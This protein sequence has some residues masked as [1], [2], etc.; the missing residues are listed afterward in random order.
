MTRRLASIVAAVLI[1][2][3]AA[4]AFAQPK[5]DPARAAFIQAWRAKVER[6]Y[7][8]PDADAVQQEIDAK[9]RIIT[10]LQD[11]VA[12]CNNCPKRDSLKRELA[13]ARG[14]SG[15]EKAGNGHVTEIYRKE[16]VAEDCLVLLEAYQGCKA[17]KGGDPSEDGP[18]GDD[19]LLFST[20]KDGQ[21]GHFAQAMTRKA[22]RDAGQTIPRVTGTFAAVFGPVPDSF[23]PPV[24]PPS[25]LEGERELA[26]TMLKSGDGTLTEIRLYTLDEWVY[27]YLLAGRLPFIRAKLTTETLAQMEIVSRAV[28]GINDAYVLKCAYKNGP[29]LQKI[30]A[31][32][33]DHR[34]DAPISKLAVIESGAQAYNRFG[35]IEGKFIPIG[36]SRTQCPDQW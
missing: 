21:A 34:P 27:D 35:N 3:S 31:F 25:Y 16:G 26:I 30:S 36:G 29:M 28:Q 15:D 6:F 19:Y 11:A 24:P 10:R 1:L 23:N 9:A 17:V 13:Q 20:C 12:A 2:A 33:W 18:C 32:W 8:G 4:S 14:L 5:Y 22:A 7:Y